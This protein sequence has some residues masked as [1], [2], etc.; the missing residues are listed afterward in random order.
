MKLI[1]EDQYNQYAKRKLKTR[2]VG[3]CT[4][5]PGACDGGCI[6]ADT[7]FECDP[8][9]CFCR[10]NC[11]NSKIRANMNIPVEQFLTNKKGW[12]I[13]TTI[14]IKKGSFICKYVGEVVTE[15]VYKSRLEK[16]YANEKNSYALYLDQG[17]LIDA[18]RMGNTARFINHSCDPNCEVQKWTVNRLPCIAIFA[19]RDIE[20]G[21][22]LSFNYKFK[23]F[24]TMDKCFC[25]SS[26]CLGQIGS[27]V[28]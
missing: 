2:D 27:K 17:Y 24:G 18:H 25:G 14:P 5:L 7:F 3:A 4:C 26:K 10:G 20:A 1:S 28:C 9:I 19:S 21:E 13:R 11:K 6:C 12:G 15:S 8:K 23:A 22:E 16:M